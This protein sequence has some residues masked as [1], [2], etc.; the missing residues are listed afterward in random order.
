MGVSA[1][2]GASSGLEGREPKVINMVADFH[3]SFPPANGQSEF[4]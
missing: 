2:F 4:E 1:Y 3:R